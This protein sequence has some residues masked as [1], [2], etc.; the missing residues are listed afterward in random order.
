MKRKKPFRSP[1]NRSR[2]HPE[3]LRFVSVILVSCAWTSLSL[4]AVADVKTGSWAKYRM[5]STYTY[6]DEKPPLETVTLR[7]GPPADG[8]D[9]KTYRWWRMESK[10]TDGGEF[11]ITVLSERVPLIHGPRGP[12]RVARYILQEG[13]EPPLEYRNAESGSALVPQFGFRRNLVPRS[14]AP[15]EAG[16]FAPQAA[17][18]G[19][20]LALWEWSEDGTFPLPENPEVLLLDPGL[21]IGTGRNFR[22]TLD[23]RITTSENYPY[24]RFTKDEYDEMIAAGI[25]YFTV[26]PEQAEWIRKR[27]VFYEQGKLDGTPFPEILYRSNY[28]GAVQF[29]DEPACYIYG[30]GDAKAAAKRPA[31]L[32]ALLQVRVRRTLKI[33]KRNYSSLA[34]DRA[35]RDARF[36]LGSMSI[37]EPDIPIWETL[38]ST[39]FYQ[40]QSQAAAG[41][42]QEGR[43]RLDSF[44]S[45]LKRIGVDAEGIGEREMLL[46]DYAFMRGASRA[47]GTDWGTSIYGQA[48]PEISPQAVTLAYDLG[49]RYVW[50][51][52]SD[53]GHHMPY[54][55]QLDLTRKLRA[56]Q[57]A[58]PRP[59]RRKLRAA[60]KVAIALP[61]GYIVD[62]GP[63]WASNDF[64]HD[65][66]NEVGV[67]YGDVVKAAVREAVD[68]LKKEESF[69]FIVDAP[70]FHPKGYARIVH[71]GLDGAV[72][73]ESSAEL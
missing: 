36:V 56:H 22:D 65:K 10:K 52:T 24:R 72:K 66:L 46:F 13:E 39:S 69:D 8:P 41:I 44:L 40:L 49:A 28:W 53:H 73:V 68:C 33:G 27:P 60:A 37:V 67:P 19:Q 42:I 12:G 20:M 23:Q 35:L 51:W 63:L 70:G 38:I 5:L 71:I 25:N 6:R 9:G 64:A 21:M 61:Y 30:D 3:F 16:P 54:G 17:L 32:A 45:N 4:A 15:S 57:K 29:V 2:R 47:W 34:L 43:Y 55:E 14:L 1:S 11:S 18:L 50:F 59:S 62:F 26:D 7:V 31:D 48:D 58:N